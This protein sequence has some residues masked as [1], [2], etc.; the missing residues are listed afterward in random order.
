M[1]LGDVGY[2]L[3]RWVSI[4]LRMRVIPATPVSRGMTRPH[5]RRHGFEVGGHKLRREASEIFFLACPKICVVPPIP[6]AQRGN[7][8]VEKIDIWHRDLD[9]FLLGTDIIHRYCDHNLGPLRPF[10]CRG[11][12]WILSKLRP[13]CHSQNLVALMSYHIG[14]CWGP[15]NWGGGVGAS[16]SC[17]CPI[18]SVVPPCPCCQKF[19]GTYPRQ[20]YGSGAYARPHL[21]VCFTR[22]LFNS[23]NFAGSAALSEVCA[24]LSAILVCINFV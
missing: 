16:Y 22:R 3:G 6:G 24:L 9:I 19:G 17:R 8:T 5:R 14:V 18:N 12:W 23:K 10:E 11:A 20:L 21:T 4:I 7:T 13:T 1:G 15:K 2:E